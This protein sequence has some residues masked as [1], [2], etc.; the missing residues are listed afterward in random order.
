MSLIC[1]SFSKLFETNS[2][3]VGIYSAIL[4]LK[5][6]NNSSKLNGMATPLKLSILELQGSCY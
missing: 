2:E 4:K 6:V 1:I 3:V 5:M